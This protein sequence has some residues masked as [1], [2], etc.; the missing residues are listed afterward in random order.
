[1]L[2]YALFLPLPKAAENQD[3]PINASL[4]KLD[5]FFHGRDRQPFY[6]FGFETTAALDGAVTVSIGLDD[7]HAIDILADKPPHGL[8]IECECIE[9]DLGPGR[10][11]RKIGVH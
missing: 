7:R 6:I 1:M 3:R 4:A 5:A 10:A 8:H 2:E 9:V 11:M